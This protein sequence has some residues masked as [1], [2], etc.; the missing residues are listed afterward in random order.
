MDSFKKRL[1][2][3]V[4]SGYSVDDSADVRLKKTALTLIPLI[5]GPAAFIWGLIYIYLGHNLS[6]SIPMS[7]AVISV[8]T[9]LHY[10]RTRNTWFLE[11]SQLILVLLLPFFLMWSLGGFFHGSA[12]M[13]WALFVPVVAAIFMD[14][15]KALFW[16]GAYFILLL[17]SGAMQNYLADTV[18][19][20]PEVARVIFFLLNIGAVSAGLYLLVG[21]TNTQ[22]AEARMAADSANRAKSDFLANMSHEI[23][24]PLNGVLGMA[25]LGL[26]ESGEEMSRKRFS[27]ILDSGQHLMVVINDILDFSKIEAGMLAIDSQPFELKAAVEKVV[28]MV[29]A[30]ARNNGLVLSLHFDKA[31]PGWVQGDSVRLQQILLNLLSNAIKF[32][33][34]G[35]VSLAVKVAGEMTCFEVRDTGIGMSD[36]EVMRLFTPFEQADTSTTRQYGGTG[37]GLAISNNLASLMDGEITVQSRSGAGSVFTLSV[38]L[39]ETAPVVSKEETSPKE[40]G[41]VLD[42][43]RVL[44]VE[45]VEMNRLILA[46]MLEYEGARVTFAENGEQALERLVEQGISGFDVVLMDIQ[47]PGM[48]G[49]EATRRIRQMTAGLPVIG[50]TAHALREEREKCLAVG[51]VDHVTKPVEPETLFKTIKRHTERLRSA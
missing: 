29:G 20:I 3:L 21:Y 13:I 44:A 49:Y 16:F 1:T 25:G 42:G 11:K 31:L 18:T 34:E 26:R 41:M 27:Y 4:E 51:M 24:T 22:L 38:P 39:P 2:R 23:R 36:E 35:E 5:I 45:D 28:G 17:V 6:G 8:L 32:T 40:S 37:L 30:Q 50:L 48:D 12:V 15:R 14:R 7:Y 43:L 19:P 9:L 10:F 46:G 33:P 47:M